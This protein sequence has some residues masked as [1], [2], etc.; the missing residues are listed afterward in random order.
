VA[1]HRLGRILGHVAI[2]SSLF[3]A[4]AVAAPVA[5]DARLRPPATASAPRPVHVLFDSIT[6]DHP[7]FSPNADG[8]LDSILVV[9]VLEDSTR[10]TIAVTPADADTP[11]RELR[12]DIKQYT[13]IRQRVT[14]NGQI[15]GVVV[16]DGEYRLRFE[17]VRLRDGT[18][19]TNDRIVQVDNAAPVPVIESI[20]P[21]IFTP[22]VGG[23]TSAL[24]T[25][26]RV[27]GANLGDALK[28]TLQA[29]VP[30]AL[31]LVDSFMGDGVYTLACDSCAT[32]ATRVP[33]GAYDLV[34]VASDPA[35]NQTQVTGRVDKDILGPAMRTVHPSAAEEFHLQH[36]DSLTG[37]AW[38]RHGVAQVDLRIVSG[39]DTLLQHLPGSTAGADTLRFRANLATALAAEGRYAL[40]F[41][42][43]DTHGVVDTLQ[44]VLVVDRTPPP[45]P[46]LSPRP[47]PTWKLQQIDLNVAVDSAATSELIRSGGAADAESLTVRKHIM[48]VVVLLEP[49]VNHLR[50]EA[51]DLAGNVSTAETVTVRW[52]T[53]VGP[54]IPEHFRAGNSFQISAGDQPANGIEVH[55]YA[56]DGTLVHRHVDKRHLLV[57]TIAWD[58]ENPSGRQVRNGAYL[59]QVL[60]HKADGRTERWRQMIAVLE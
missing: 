40:T 27:T 59:V 25:R 51:L 32:P 58:L 7:Q 19:I 28:A 6:V 29:P 38:D 20:E 60:L 15:G 21:P 52:E 9:Y 18:V 23:A 11:R 37:R 3:G 53:S 2:L 46:L 44:H 47:A 48:P 10:V 49:G 42:G 31:R 22:G 45:R 8:K 30:L 13:N 1:R 24:R 16:A 56:T 4:F 26:I 55:I 33:D 41:F 43:R 50:F 54:A 57:Y 12:R 14:W 36:A 17:G 35:G 5:P 39:P 34:V